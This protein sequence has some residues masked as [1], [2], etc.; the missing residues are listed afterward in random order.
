MLPP[1]KP[2]ASTQVKPKRDS[3]F[4]LA[5]LSARVFWAHYRHSPL[6]AGATLLGIALAVTLLIGVKATN[7]NAIRSY[8]E[9]TE[10][11]SLRADALLTPPVGQEHLDEDVYFALKRAGLSRSL[12]VVTGHV[13]GKQGQL[14]QIEGSDLVAAISLQPPP[15]ANAS[16][17]KDLRAS[18]P[19]G[20]LLSGEGLVIM[21]DSFA[22][23]VAPEGRLELDDIHLKVLTIDDKWGLGSAI[24]ADI[25]LAQSLLGMQGKLSY[26]ALFNEGG[27]LSV[28]KAQLSQLG[29]IPK[30]ASFTLEDQGQT[31]MALTRS[32]HL[33]LNAMSM[34]AF[35]VGLFI[36][37]NGV[38][39]S[40]MKRQKLLIQLLQQGLTRQALMLALLLELLLLVL[41]GTGIGFILGL[42]LSHWLQ[43]MVAMTLEQLY[44][45]HL[46]PGKWQWRWLVEATGLTLVAAFAACLPLYL[47]LTRQPLAQGAHRYQHTQ[48]QRQTHAKQFA[49]A[50]ALL[51]LVA[52]GF[53]L[54]QHYNTS[55]ILLALVTLAIPLLLPQLLH[56]AINGLQP[57]A[58]A[59]LWQYMVSETRELIAPL[60]LAMMAILL[61]LSANIAMNTLV[62]SFE[63]TLT[64]WLE[65]RLHADVYLRPPSHQMA[66]I[67]A[68]LAKDPRVSELY[69]QWQIEAKLAIVTGSDGQNH[70]QGL[71]RPA[72]PAPSA[73]DLPANVVDAQ[74]AQLPIQL[75]SRDDYSLQ[76]TSALKERLPELWSA[77]MTEPYILLSEPLAIKYQLQLGNRV[78]VD[79]LTQS[80]NG[81]DSAREH[82]PQTLLIAGIYYDHGNTGNE[83]IISQHTWRQAQLPL[84]PVS[85]AARFYGQG[86]KSRATESELE[87]IQQDLARELGLAQAQVVSQSKIK[88]Q[89]IAMFKRTFAIT[90]VLNSL[91]LL[92][93]AIGLFSACLMLT[94]AR[95]APLARLY[96][97]GVSRRQLGTL[98]ATQMLIVVL[99]TCLI[100]MPTGA[101]LGY[102]LIHKITLQA[103]GWSIAMFW[104]WQTYAN[105]MIIALGSCALAVCLPLYWQT[106]KPIIT[107]LQQET[108]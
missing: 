43:P 37:Y 25:S 8:S 78:T 2:Q 65:T 31:L 5:W 13:A 104:D 50:C 17:P 92:V 20:E 30:R 99:L 51:A 96:A 82:A 61:A 27:H 54:S 71:G 42:Q 57:L 29:L 9:A 4:T 100:A 40:L 62:G 6:Q 48:A 75:L 55:L 108:L 56:W 49:F 24:L 46:L 53:P 68:H 22:A 7:D 64:T 32:F 80:L 10:L 60:S 12:A 106:R 86:G 15:S 36:A 14:W 76:H 66:A 19:L 93:A 84:L 63:R 44:G 90:L 21:S 89:A 72:A 103:F 52:V 16:H 98:V 97:L 94:Q 33:N 39:Y 58:K 11:L 95:Q 79:V 101:I 1:Q 41:L 18:L 74:R 85:L 105:A 70:N 91:T 23:K 35:I 87:Q 73:I 45:A 77:N 107:S 38:R 26:I 47:D 81:H 83:A 67:Q 102:L 88:N 34:L 28:L 59:G 3:A 69:Q